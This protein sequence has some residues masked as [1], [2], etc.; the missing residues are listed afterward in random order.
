MT[1]GFGHWAQHGCVRLPM[2]NLKRWIAAGLLGISTGAFASAT[3]DGGSGLLTLSA[4]KVGSATFSN[5]VLVLINPANYSFRLQAATLQTPAGPADITFDG[6]TGVL[7][8]PSV[9][10]GSATYSVTFQITDPITYT[11]VL[12]SATLLAPSAEA[13]GVRHRTIAAWGWGGGG[14]CVL[15]RD[16]TARCLGNNAYGTLGVPTGTETPG[17]PTQVSTLSG[18]T[19]L[20]AGYQHLCA[21]IADGSVRCWGNNQSG[22][23]G[24]GT[25]VASSTPVTVSGI[26]G[27]VAIAAGAF[28]SCALLG[29]GTVRCWGSDAYGELGNGKALATVATPVVMAGGRNTCIV[30]ADGT[31]QCLGNGT[32]GELGNNS[33]ATQLALVSAF[34]VAGAVGVYITGFNTC[35]LSGA[36]N[37]A[38][39]GTNYEGVLGN[40]TLA[41]SNTATAVMDLTNAISLTNGY[42]ASDHKCAVLSDGTMRC[43][44]FNGSGQLGDGTITDSSVPVNVV[45]INDA[46][47]A[48][49]GVYCACAVRRDG[50]VWCWGHRP[51][52]GATSNVPQPVAGIVNAQ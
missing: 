5:V 52:D 1:A 31:V 22:Q 39:W 33:T 25:V 26:A 34:N 30:K 11:F 15:L 6:N 37:A 20:I 13:A 29:D 49:A 2:K 14:I 51:W 12:T 16:G 47:A 21:L 48:A 9:M 17:V 43:W 50:T 4:V 36:G 8:I 3:F 46:V 23:L 35:A 41:S 42:G 44:G 45:G 10:V 32:Y 27:A 24:N 38:C 28:H 18:A 19:Q 40:G 7:N